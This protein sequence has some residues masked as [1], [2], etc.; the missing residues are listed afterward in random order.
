MQ[1]SEISYEKQSLGLDSVPNARH[2]GTYV[3][4]DG[5]KVN[6]KLLF[7]SGLLL[8]ATEH[9]LSA[10]EDQYHISC[11]IDLRT[12]YEIGKMPDKTVEHA[13][14]L[15]MPVMDRNNNIWMTMAKVE[16]C[17]NEEK[18]LNFARTDTAKEMV[19]K[20]YIGFVEDEFCQLQ[21]A[22][23]IETLLHAKGPVL[24]HCSQGKDRTGLA[25]AFILAILGV[26][27]ETII[28]DFDL[29]N[30]SYQPTV[31]KL[32]AKLRQLGGTDADVEVIQSLEGVN[33]K[34]FKDALD[35]I[36]QKYGSMDNYIKEIFVLT[37]E[38][39]NMLR[40]KYLE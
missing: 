29:T 40:N 17:N 24:W 31:D 27:R 15:N 12:P 3:G 6:G 22:A 1:K 33:T 2:F 13:R 9:D 20:M 18:L 11:V 28:K 16:G 21:F 26:D 30:T 25:S 32:A 7:R 14:A 19:K 10:L 4:A 23:F 34:Y 39:I 36:D 8:M 37:D 35:F 5:R 38:E